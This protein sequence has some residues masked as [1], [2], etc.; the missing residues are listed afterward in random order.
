MAKQ[1]FVNLA[2]KDLERSK[3]FYEGLG[4]TI[5]PQFTDEAGACVVIS[6]TIFVMILTEAKMQEFTPK[7]IVDAGTMTE[8]LNAIS[9]DSKD[10][11]D[12]I[13]SKALA[14]GGTEARD[15]QDLGFMYSRSF[16]DPDGHIWEPFFMDMTQ[17]PPAPGS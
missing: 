12:D 10:D 5:N 13:M 9:F 16:Q 2:V 1:I 6:D 3:Q 15:P 7:Q 14:N 11:V 8:V 17:A 4:W